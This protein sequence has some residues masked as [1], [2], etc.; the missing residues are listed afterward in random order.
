MAR[1]RVYAEAT[2]LWL[3]MPLEDEDRP[4]R[5]LAEGLHL[6]RG[7]GEVDL[8]LTAQVG[9]TPEHQLARFSTEGGTPWMIL[10]GDVP[11]FSCWTFPRRIP[12]IAG[13]GGWLEG[14]EG[15]MFLE[16]SVTTE[17]ARGRGIAPAAWS[18]IGDALAEDGVRQLFTPVNPENIP[19][20]RALEKVGFVE[21]ARTVTTRRGRTNVAVEV[22]RP[23]GEWMAL[24]VARRS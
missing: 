18:S 14:P 13:P 15:A 10:D 24:N 11:L 5:P 17:A 19:V 16:D 8:A 6:L 3:V 4:R 22:L 7:A 1:Q 20:R 2:H 21:V 23:E 9:A 12:T